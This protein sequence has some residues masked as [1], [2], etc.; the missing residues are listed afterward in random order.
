MSLRQMFPGGIVKPGFNPL[1]AP[2]P[3]YTYYLSSWG[4][5]TNGQLGLGNTTNYSSPNQIGAGTDWAYVNGGYNFS[6]AIK[7]DGTAWAWG[8]NGYG[9]LGLSDRT[10]RSS[11]AQIGSLTNWLSITAGSYSAIAV[12]TDGTLW[13]W[14][15]NQLGEIGKGNTTSYSSPVQVGS[16]TNWSYATIKNTDYCIAVK[17]DGTLWCWGNN[18]NGQLGLGNTTSYS[19]P[20]QIGALT[21]WTNN[22][23]VC[24]ETTAAIKSNGSLWT[25]G[26]GYLG[27]LGNNG[28]ANYRS[29]PVQIGALTNWL[30]ISGAYRC[31]YSVKT[32]G[33]IWCWGSN[34][35][36]QLGLGNT[37]D[38]SSPKQIGA[39]TT[40]SLSS[41]G[42]RKVAAIKTDGTAWSWGSNTSGQLGLGN[43]TNYSSPKQIGSLTNWDLVSSGDNHVLA[44]TY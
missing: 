34:V 43:T 20:K 7:T 32:D 13:G 39:L 10:G 12:K 42:G 22:I 41:A 15:R 40:W 11:P 31:L 17:T 6:F 29:S 8:T 21:D 2:T 28:A 23:A 19:S 24:Q 37:T 1:A 25:W 5:N 4:Q 33:T 27:T 14:G 18:S 30:S 35:N 26:R 3:S 9:P 44:L 36:G 38:Y 16:L